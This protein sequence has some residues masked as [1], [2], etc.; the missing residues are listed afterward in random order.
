MAR[1]LLTR[2]EWYASVVA[3]WAGESC[4]HCGRDTHP[5]EI[6]DDGLVAIFC[7]LS[8]RYYDL[9]VESVPLTFAEEPDAPEDLPF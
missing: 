8:C 1:K 3:A 7:P 2:W 9:G 5:L 4:P 6:A